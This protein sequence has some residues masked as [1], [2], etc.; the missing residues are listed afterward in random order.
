[1]YRALAR[2][3]LSLSLSVSLSLS[4]SLSHSLTLALT[5]SLFTQYLADVVKEQQEA[6]ENGG[7]AAPPVIRLDYAPCHVFTMNPQQKR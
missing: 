1:M 2:L 3:S 4:L 5:H 7:H 6:E